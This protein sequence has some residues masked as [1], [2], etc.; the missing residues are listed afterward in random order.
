MPRLLRRLS[1]RLILVTCLGI[2]VTLAAPVGWAGFGCPS[3][4]RGASLEGRSIGTLDRDLACLGRE[5]LGGAQ[6]SWSNFDCD[7]AP[8]DCGARAK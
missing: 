7:G 4:H 5:R 2:G 1:S 3:L 6:E 8:D